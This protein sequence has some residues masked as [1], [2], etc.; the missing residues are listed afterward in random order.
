MLFG[1]LIGIFDL[2]NPNTA[3]IYPLKIKKQIL[4]GFF[5]P[6]NSGNAEIYPL[7]IKNGFLM[8]KWPLKTPV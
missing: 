4:M 6:E 2:I 3:E 8:G 5:S 7:E 1:T